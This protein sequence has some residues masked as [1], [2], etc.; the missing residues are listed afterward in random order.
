[1]CSLLRF[2]APEADVR[3]RS[4]AFLHN[5][6]SARVRGLSLIND[7]AAVIP[8]SDPSEHRMKLSVSTVDASAARSRVLQFGGL[9]PKATL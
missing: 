4:Q 8:A 2:Y 6:G 1:M 9:D 3:S 5:Q 7:L